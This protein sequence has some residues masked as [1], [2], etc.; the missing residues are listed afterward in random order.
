MPRLLYYSPGSSGG[1]AD[2]AHEQ[3]IALAELGVEVVMLSSPAYS[4]HKSGGS[5][6]LLPLLKEPRP[7]SGG[8]CVAIRKLCNFYILLYN[9]A[10]LAQTISRGKF[11]HV[12]F[13]SYAEYFA[14]LWA[15]RFRRFARAGAV[16]GAVVHDP[17][18]DYVYG[19]LWWHRRSIT[20]AY[21]F[22]REA[23]VHDNI[24]LDTGIPMPQMCTTIIPIGSLHFP[25][26]T[27]SREETRRRLKIPRDAFLILSFGHIRDGK[28]L[29][30]AIKS[31]AQFPNIFLL[32]AGKEQSSG[33]KPIRFY[34]E[35]AKSLGV[36]N[37]CRWLNE[38]I[39]EDA[40]GNLFIASDLILLSYSRNFRS[41]SAVLSAA[42]TYRKPCLAS[43]GEGNLHFVVQKYTLGWLI[44]PDS[45]SALRQGLDRAIGSQ[46][47][48][49]WD[50]Y[51]TEQSW[52]HNAKIVADRMFGNHA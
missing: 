14:P 21:S 46:I 35:L 16:F 32:V 36:H 26:P 23:F 1:L 20:S 31:I 24:L 51:E 42:V 19:P 13:G 52:S 37:R 48:P 45:V 11:R 7:H 8:E 17:V 2:Y 50:A 28:N 22:M 47:A 5:Y 10:K 39:Q 34:Q 18:R 38:F 40:V 12:L 41:A 9:Y 43:C 27:E 49:R 25:L 33:Q 3:A 15:W 44:E 4:R 30:L 29:D 6:T